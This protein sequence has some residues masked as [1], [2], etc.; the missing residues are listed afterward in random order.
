MI[1]LAVADDSHQIARVHV[2]SW[3]HI[4]RGLLPDDYLDSL[5]ESER[6]ELWSQNIARAIGTTGIY[7]KDG[8]IV[9]FIHL[10]PCRDVGSP[11]STGEVA[12]IYVDPDS[13]RRGIGSALMHWAVER[14]KRYGW[15]NLVLYVLD[16]NQQA[17]AFY[18]SRG[19]H[20]DGAQKED[21]IGGQKVAE[22]RY[23]KRLDA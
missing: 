10:C 13:W 22:I 9:G 14:A 7:E 2:K 12:A 21:E 5:D 3:Q 16:S 6:A 20:N 11:S 17:R 19:W 15:V 8:R 1:R 4:Y 18:E 23:R